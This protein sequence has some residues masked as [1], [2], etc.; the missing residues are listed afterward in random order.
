MTRGRRVVGLAVAAGVLALPGPAHAQ[1]SLH[2]CKHLQCGRIAVPLDRTGATPGTV[3]LY[4]ERQRARRGPARGVTMLLAGGPG[5][6]ATGAY[7]DR[8]KNPYGEFRSLT[9]FN[10]V[11][12]FDGRGTGRSGL[13]RCPELERAN[14]IDAGAEAAACAQRLGAKRA[15]YRTTDAV[16]DMEAVR[17]ALGVDKL[18]LVGVSYGTFLAQAYA[19]RYPTHVERVLLDSVL[20]VSGW[21]PFYLDIFG[22]VPRV[23]R[24][25]CG[26]I[27]AAFTDDAVADLGRLVA[28]LER[29]TLHGHV[30]LPNGRRARTSLTR[31][32]LF[33][34]LVSGDL[35]ELLRASF[36]GAVKSARRGDL[37]PILRLSRH[38]AL[39]EGSGSPRDFSSALYAATTCEEI[40]FP[41]TRFSDPA[42]RFAQ[43]SAAVAQIPEEAL[44]PFDRA[45]DEGNDFIRMC[46]RWPEASP[47]PAAGP[48]AGSLPDVPVL[49]LS[50]QMDLRTPVETAR[51]AAAD[52]PHAQV[53]TIPA[54]G[55]STLT[56]DF[57][58]CTREAAVRFFRGQPVPARCKRG[59]SFFFPFPPAPLALGELRAAKGVPGTRG[60]AISAAQLTLFDVTV[61]FLSTVLTA[62]DLDLKGG[63]LRGG[64]WTLNL[65]D[66]HPVLR[67]YG[68]EYLPGVRVTG[69]VRGIG[70]R[71]ERSTLRLSGPRTPDGVVQI[72]SKWITGQLGG[73]PVRSRVPGSGSSA[74]A[75]TAG[76]RS[77]VT[78]TQLLR[79]ARRLAHRP[80]RY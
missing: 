10:D 68:V 15:F 63:G 22:A 35:D 18:T 76:A 79:I 69:A 45:T 80:R 11:V 58:R 53:L 77:T 26:R 4:V 52:W 39:S 16:D 3:S 37:D 41:W 29:G 44:Y 19:A 12:A 49:M 54:T 17:A 36:P 55:H 60:R 34:T 5:Q 74:S 2:S 32:E 71:H 43:I 38:A 7:N 42:S 40:P 6:P 46:R 66:K 57:S 51:S 67:L 72:G 59:T 56:A 70:T 75:A 28:R 78:R 61:E 20:D 9:P 25:V 48:P 24:A 13:L 73:K 8:S 27:C 62:Q 1:L 23:L 64:R 65:D 50:G 21:D 31:Q 47:A 33:F 14:L 30:T